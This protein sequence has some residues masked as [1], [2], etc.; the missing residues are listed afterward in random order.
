MAVNEWLSP[1]AMGLLEC[2]YAQYS[3]SDIA[4]SF[5]NV[6]TETPTPFPAVSF[7]DGTYSIFVYAIIDHFIPFMPRYVR[8]E[9]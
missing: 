8:G 1:N 4:V 5:R 6:E 3:A 9:L 2:E 7:I